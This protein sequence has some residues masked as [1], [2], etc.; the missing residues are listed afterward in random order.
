MLSRYPTQ[1]EIKTIEAYFPP[2]NQ[3]RAQYLEDIVWA[4]I[5][6]SEFLYRH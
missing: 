6:S 3:N 5:N 1:D 4:L 2:R